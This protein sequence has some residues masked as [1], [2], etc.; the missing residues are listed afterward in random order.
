[1][2]KQYLMLQMLG[3]ALECSDEV[4][5]AFSSYCNCHLVTSVLAAAGCPVPS[6]V[7][8]GAQFRVAPSAV[9]GVSTAGWLRMGL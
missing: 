4:G 7:T 2:L 9:L 5:T 8:D 3:T 6:C 1:M